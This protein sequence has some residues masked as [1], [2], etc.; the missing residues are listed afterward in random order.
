VQF[1]HECGCKLSLGTEKFCPECG[2]N[3]K[4]REKEE[5]NGID[6]TDTKGDVI[7]V[8]ITGTGN[9]IGK[10]VDY[11]VQ[12]NVIYLNVSGNSSKEIIIDSLQKII[13]APTQIEQNSIAKDTVY[14]K[15]IKN[16][17]EET[18]KT[19]KQITSILQEV[20]NIEKKEGT[21]PIEEIRSEEIKISTKWLLLKE[22]ILKGNEY[23]YKK[24]YNNAIQCFDNALEIEPNNT[25][26][27]NNKGL[28]LDD[29]CKHY[30]AIEC[31]DRALEINT[32]NANAWNNKGAAIY[33]LGKYN[34]A[35]QCFDKAIEIEPN[36]SKTWYNKG[37]SLYYLGKYNEAIEC[38]DRALEINTNNA[39][40][41]NN[42][43]LSLYYLGKYNEAIEC[44]DKAL[45]IEP[46]DSA[47]LY[48]K[49][50]SLYYLGKYNEAIECYDRALVINPNNKLFIE[51]RKVALEKL[52][53]TEK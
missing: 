26:A 11:T 32:N 31:Y 22:H 19:Q 17:I 4:Q 2:Q 38:Y 9:I 30:E 43:G 42:K 10:N 12:E 53:K 48:N 5:P 33:H 20:D 1:C 41:W 23:Y 51:N 28:A 15:D 6:I 7:G 21:Q 40:A 24:K 39:N 16:K 45:E 34:E 49:G 27:W 8:G 44:Y 52:G 37:L 36:Y 47:V 25:N 46:N 14:D 35:I 3:L 50:L 13:N 29:L 18:N